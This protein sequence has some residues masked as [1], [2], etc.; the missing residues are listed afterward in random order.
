M[1]RVVCIGAHPDDVEIG[2]GGTIARLVQAGTSVTIVD[3]TDGEPTP[4]GTREIRAREAAEAA[5]VLG[6]ERVTLSLPNRELADTPEARRELAEVLRDTR[7]DALFIPYPEDAHP[8]HIAASQIALAARFWSKLTKTDMRGEPH[9]PA[10]VY[11]HMAVH[12][13]IIRPPSFVHDITE[14]LDV[15]MRAVRCYRSQFE[16]NPAN[17]HLIDAIEAST[18]MWGGTIGA[19]AGE[20]IFALETLGVSDLGALI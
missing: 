18:R 12:L 11:R 15:K 9:Y 4:F 16:S 6:A 20:P 5:A 2:L 8:D 19:V 14:H 17:R 7:P 10:R 3:L 1:R 13:K